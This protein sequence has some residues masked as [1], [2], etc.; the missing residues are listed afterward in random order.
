MKR[1]YKL[2]FL[3]IIAISL[4]TV[5]FVYLNIL[6]NA[7]NSVLNNVLEFLEDV[8][9]LELSKYDAQLLGT[10]VTYPDWLDG[11]PQQVGK[12]T[13][14]SEINK[15]DVLFKL[16]NNTLSWCLVRQIEGTMQYLD[17]PPMNM[18]D[19]VDGLLER[20]QTYS[21]NSEIQQMRSLLNS[22]DFTEKI[23][24]ME[25]NMKLTAVIN[26]F[27]V[28]VN[29]QNTFKGTNNAV[30]VSFHNGHFYAFSDNTQ[31]R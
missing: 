23:T 27:S 21:K 5:L 30:V 1:H 24:I 28:S 10:V 19:T 11:I 8:V 22:V 29:F 25:G 7:E 18:H 15:L 20:Y 31:D 14:D 2:F 16:R 17:S 6:D 12:I 26:L 4:L 13:L 9:G 3:S